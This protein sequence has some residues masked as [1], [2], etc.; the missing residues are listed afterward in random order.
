MAAGALNPGDHI[1]ESDGLQ[2]SYTVVGAGDSV[3]VAHPVG[4]G[5]PAV[6]LRNGFAH[7]LESEHKLVYFTPR[8]N[9][10]S[11]KPADETAMSSKAM[12]EDIEQLRKHL[13]L[14]AI[15]VLLGHS[16]GAC[17]VLQYAQ[18]YPSR[19]SKLV[20]VDAETHD[21]PPNDNFQ[22][23]AAK[24]KDDP[25][26]GPALAAMIGSRQSPPKSDEEFGQMLDSIL[27]Y[28]FNDASFA[29]TFRE[30][31]DV[32]VDPMSVWAFLRQSA[33]DSE[34][35]N[36]LPHVADAGKVTAKTLVV[37]GKQDALCSQVAAAAIAEGIPDSELVLID[38]CG[39][40]PWVEKHDEFMS[41][42][43]RF[44]KK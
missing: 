41:A 40:V 43:T 14:D 16:N 38:D 9:G 7:N 32:D 24:R 17:I 44:L 2:L 13:G 19:V 15:P 33:C 30:Q 18:Q 27:P 39:H 25:I 36:R 10:R 8:G 23:W 1:F 31:L 37:W 11:G 35:A 34:P 6:Y 5:A 20:L 3:I 22:Q 28:Y 29:T 42:L 21:S 4:W 12:A 26:F